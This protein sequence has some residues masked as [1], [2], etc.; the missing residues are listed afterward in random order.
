MGRS[1]LRY[2]VVKRY[3]NQSRDPERE[4]KPPEC[5]GAERACRVRR[6]E[7]GTRDAWTRGHGHMTLLTRVTSHHLHLAAGIVEVIEL[8]TLQSNAV[9]ID[10]D[11]TQTLLL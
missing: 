10:P 5:G 3:Q 1:Y 6:V 8:L 9:R 11:L 7:E 2:G 4:R